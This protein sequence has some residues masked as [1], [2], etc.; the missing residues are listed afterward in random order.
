M[1]ILQ[2]NPNNTTA[3]IIDA[4]IK[5]QIAILK[6]NAAGRPKEEDLSKF[7]EAYQA[8]LNMQ[9]AYDKV[10]GLGYQDMPKEAYQKWLKSIDQAKKKQENKE[11]QERLKKE[12]EYLKKLKVTIIDRTRD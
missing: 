9:A 7:P 5:T 8:Y 2:V 1:M 4:N 12:I 10:D 11:V 3:N 6:I